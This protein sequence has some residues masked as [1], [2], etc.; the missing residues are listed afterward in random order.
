M[1]SLSLKNNNIKYL[2][3]V[4]DSFAKCAW[5]KPENHKKDEPVPN[6]FMEIVDECHSKPNKLWVDQGR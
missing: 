6:A 1:R 2:L 3:C 5:V 4:I